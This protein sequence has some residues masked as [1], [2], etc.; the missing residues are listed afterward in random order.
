[1]LR[2]RILHAPPLPDPCCLQLLNLA[3]SVLELGVYPALEVAAADLFGPAARLPPNL[4]D[5]PDI[6]LGELID[7]GELPGS[8][9]EG[10]EQLKQ[11]GPPCQVCPAMRPAIRTSLVVPARHSQL[12]LRRRGRPGLASRCFVLC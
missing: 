12:D 8:V 4:D 10:L 11:V 7:E 5:V 6:L 2:A 1:M 3:S 9:E